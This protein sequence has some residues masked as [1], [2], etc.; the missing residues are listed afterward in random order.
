MCGGE[1]GGG[2]KVEGAYACCVGV[3]VGGAHVHVCVDMDE[4]LHDL[5]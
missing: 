4:R 3:Y 5:L 2:G 1:G